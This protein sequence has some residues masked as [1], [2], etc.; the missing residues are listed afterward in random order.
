MHRTF[1]KPT[2]PGPIWNSD[3][4]YPISEGISDLEFKANADLSDGCNGQAKINTH[5]D[6]TETDSNAVRPKSEIYGGDDLSE[7]PVEGNA[8]ASKHWIR[9]PVSDRR[10]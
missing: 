5:F 3:V 9:S 6:N 8:G 10:R 4:N 1:A 7:K 2:F